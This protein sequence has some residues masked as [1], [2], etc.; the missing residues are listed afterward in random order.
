MSKS[1]KNMVNNSGPKIETCGAPKIVSEEGFSNNLEICDKTLTG[2]FF[3]KIVFT[4]AL[5]R[6]DRKY[7]FKGKM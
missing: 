4:S 5:L 2:L 3:L 1:H 6:Q 7:H